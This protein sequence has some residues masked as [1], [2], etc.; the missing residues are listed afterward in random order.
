MSQLLKFRGF[1]ARKSR[2][3]FSQ[4]EDEALRALVKEYG[5]TNWSL[6]SQKMRNRNAR[7]CRDR[8]RCYLRPTLVKSQWT[9]EEDR[10]LM[11]KYNEIGP[12]WSII[13]KSLPGRSEITMKNRWKLL[14]SAKLNGMKM[15]NG[16][17][18]YYV[19]YPPNFNM[20]TIQQP[21]Q[22]IPIALIPNK[23]AQQPPQRQQLQQQPQQIPANSNAPVNTVVVVNNNTN[24]KQQNEQKKQNQKQ[25]KT[26]VIKN[27]PAIVSKK[28]KTK[29]KVIENKSQESS[30]DTSAADGELA[31]NS[32]SNITTQ[33]SNSQNLEAFFNSL[34]KSPMLRNPRNLM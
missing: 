14:S 16:N 5:E 24:Q 34:T 21:I 8:W 2:Q 29:K 25:P 19:D 9:D 10:L 11:E 18:V 22:N 32:N 30:P 1:S 13:G 28:F 3:A 7:Q 31:T 15:A 4:A 27:A 33:N 23:Q 12:K 6:I 20:R 26:V 17:P